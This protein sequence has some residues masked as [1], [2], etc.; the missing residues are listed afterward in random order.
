MASI[1][2]ILFAMDG[3]YT[4]TN[5]RGNLKNE[6]KLGSIIAVGISIVIGIYILYATITALPGVGFSSLDIVKHNQ[7]I[8]SVF[9]IMI[10]FAIMGIVNGFAISAT[11]FY[12]DTEKMER[13]GVISFM[14]NKF[15]IKSPRNAAFLGLFLMTILLYV[16][17]VPIGIYGVE[18]SYGEDY[19]FNGQNIGRLYTL[20]DMLTNFTSLLVFVIIA[21]SIVG[22]II[23]RRT[24]KIKVTKIRFF[25]PIAYTAVIFI[26]IGSAYMLIE[27]I[28][29][30]TG[31]R[32]ADATTSI[33]NFAI[34]ITILVISGLPIVLDAFRNK[35]PK[36]IRKSI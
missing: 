4:V 35:K 1:P 28:V 7:W 14:Q 13:I 2:A 10:M 31:F 27:T 20:C 18:S 34:M 25:I 17:L 32:G 23:N 24:N 11:N 30:M 29:N 3:F 19:Q 15:K 16:V 12:Q 33:I 8:S 22:G 21:V 6:K 36:K 26:L 5:L 9:N